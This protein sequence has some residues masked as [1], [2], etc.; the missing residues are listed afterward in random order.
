MIFDWYWKIKKDMDIENDFE[1]DHILRIFI[2]LLDEIL[3]LIS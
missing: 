3:D 1:N 2:N